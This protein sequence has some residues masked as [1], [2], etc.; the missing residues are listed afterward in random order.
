[1]MSDNNLVRHLD[2]CETMGNATTICISPWSGF[3][4]R[5]PG[6]NKLHIRNQHGRKPPSPLRSRRGTVDHKQK[7]ILQSS[8]HFERKRT[9]KKFVALDSN[10][11]RVH[12]RRI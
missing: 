1:M 8:M 6:K 12:T 11:C 5:V 4:R 9:K 10:Q 3:E 7:K 2:A